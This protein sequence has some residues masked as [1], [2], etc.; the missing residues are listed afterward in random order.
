[1]KVRRVSSFLPL[2]QWILGTELRSAFLCGS[3]LSHLT[4]ICVCV[5]EVWRTSPPAKG[6]R[7]MPGALLCR[8]LTPLRV[9]LSRNLEESGQK[10]PPILL[11]LRLQACAAMPRF[12][13]GVWTCDLSA[14]ASE[15]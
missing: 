5:C 8:H 13:H 10:A 1:M 7:R 14:Q 9:D 15:T 4:G 2:L 3:L 6:K 12:S 11:S